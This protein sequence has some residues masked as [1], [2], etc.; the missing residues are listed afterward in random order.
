MRAQST[1]AV[2]ARK[3]GPDVRPDRCQ[4]A[5]ITSV[6]RPLQPKERTAFMAALFQGLLHR[7]NEMGD[8]ELG[9]TLRDLQRRYFTPPAIDARETART[10]DSHSPGFHIHHLRRQLAR[11]A[12]R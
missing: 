10:V 11:R 3:G 5:A 7:R 12:A 1:R 8:G 6:T 2:S 9:R 4:V